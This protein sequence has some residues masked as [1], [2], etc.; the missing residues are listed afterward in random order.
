MAL[1]WKTLEIDFAHIM[2]SHVT[3]HAFGSQFHLGSELQLTVLILETVSAWDERVDRAN[4]RGSAWFFT[5]AFP[6][7]T[8]F[9]FLHG[10]PC[11]RV[12]VLY[13]PSTNTITTAYP[14]V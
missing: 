1:N 11:H 9:N 2:G 12:Q 10:M 14:F 7:Q 5:K 6:F 4:E 13:D 3:E 8:G